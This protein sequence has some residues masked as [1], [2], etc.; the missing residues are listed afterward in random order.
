[1]ATDKSQEQF[2]K[3]DCVFSGGEY[4]VMPGSEF[5]KVGGALDN[6]LYARSNTGLGFTVE[7]RG[8]EDYGCAHTR[9]SQERPVI[10]MRTV[11]L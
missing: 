1:M 8:T 10:F 4:T 9:I 3:H 11:E 6:T 5:Y 7:L 2:L